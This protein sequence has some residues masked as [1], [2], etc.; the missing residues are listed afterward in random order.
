MKNKIL[1]TAIALLLFPAGV[2][3][4][5]TWKATSGAVSFKIKNA[6]ITVTG[7]FSGFNSTLAFGADKL[8][9]SSLKG[10]VDVG[11][12]KTGNDK[13]DEDLKGDKYFDA[14]KYKTIEIKSV[15]L[16]K[17]GAQYAGLFNVTIKG[18]TKQVEI[19]FSFTQHG[20]EAEFKGDFT[21][22]RRDY[23]V[24]GKTLTM[25]DDADVSIDVKAK[26]YGTMAK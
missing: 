15:K 22:N 23:G 11:T 5:T 12:I 19:P 3:A 24:G 25:S 9:S 16:Y 6:G 20:N 21:I 7:R 18:V 10:S 8:A 14:G 26:N 17:K 1:S 4:Q 2:F 13:R